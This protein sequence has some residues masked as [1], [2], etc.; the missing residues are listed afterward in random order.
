M[1]HYVSGYTGMA[2]NSHRS[3]PVISSGSKSVV[4]C[5]NVQGKDFPHLVL[6][7]RDKTV[8]QN[9]TNTCATGD[10]PSSVQNI[11]RPTF[12]KIVSNT[13]GPHVSSEVIK[14]MKRTRKGEYM[15]V[16]IDEALYNAGVAELKHSLISR[17]VHARGDKPLLTDELIKWLNDIWDTAATWTLIPIGEGYYNILFNS[18]EDRERILAKQTWVVKPGILRLQRWVLDFNPYRVNTSIAHVWI[19]ISELSLEYWNVHI[20]TTLASAIGSVI[21][22]DD[23]TTSKPI[24]HFARV[25]GGIRPQAGVGRVHNV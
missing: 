4:S 1:I 8:I 5:L 10:I 7:D 20:L 18:P 6:N 22:I 19:R 17:M 12:T 13:H 21:K 16:R 2:S 3:N 15:S 24:G 23:R 11:R 9:T 25:F 14:G